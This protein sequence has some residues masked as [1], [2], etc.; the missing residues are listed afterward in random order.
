MVG[1]FYSTSS[2]QMPAFP[3]Q[4]AAVRAACPD[5]TLLGT[6]V[7]CHDVPRMAYYT[8][9][10]SLLKNVNTWNIL[11]DGIPVVYQGQE[12]RFRGNTDPYNREALWLS[13]FSTNATLYVLI[14]FLNRTPSPFVT[15]VEFRQSVIKKDGEYVTTLS[16]TLYTDYETVA[17]MK[18]EVMM[19]L[20]NAGLEGEQ[21]TI[22]IP[23]SKSSV[24]TTGTEF[25]DIIT[26][27]KLKI[28]ST[29]DLISTI[30]NGM[31]QVKIL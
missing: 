26:C 13:G 9:D 24:N 14:K 27:N 6:F 18:K 16:E 7:E 8:P 21:Y 28:A 15:Y 10:L 11:F 2:T 29:G 1:A 5:P 12:Q 23:M 20:S 19:V 3:A 30:V 4:I 25:T 31:P 17:F 22:T